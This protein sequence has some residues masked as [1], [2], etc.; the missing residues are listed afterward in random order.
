MPIPALAIKSAKSVA[1]VAL[2]M[3]IFFSLLLFFRFLFCS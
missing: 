3:F 2:F 1:G